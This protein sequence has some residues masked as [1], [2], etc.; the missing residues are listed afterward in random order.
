MTGTPPA[1]SLIGLG[2]LSWVRMRVLAARYSEELEGNG[3][4][5]EQDHP[6]LTQI[7]HLPDTARG[8]AQP[9]AIRGDLRLGVPA[10]MPQVSTTRIPT[11]RLVIGGWGLLRAEEPHATA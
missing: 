1:L 8:S 3:D 10:F 6:P 7:R 5:H 9:C 11:P 4:A 2:L